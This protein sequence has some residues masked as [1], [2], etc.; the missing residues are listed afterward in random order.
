MERLP[1]FVANHLFLFSLLLSILML[2]MWNIYGDVLSGVKML[3]PDEVTRLI[4]REDA[5]VID[6]RTQKEFE[7]GHIIDAINIDVKDLATQ[8]DKLK[9]YKDKGIIFCCTSG[10]ISVKEVRKLMV[11]GFEKVYCLRGGIMAWQN[12]SLPLTKGR[13]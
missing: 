3:L 7:T 2:L 9:K 13:K 1:E 11:D 8:L 5:Q 10:T 4:N 6:I 12:A